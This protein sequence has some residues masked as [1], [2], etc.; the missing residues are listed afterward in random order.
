MSQT[1]DKAAGTQ[2]SC[3]FSS[4]L[5]VWLQRYIH[6]QKLQL[7]PAP[8][9][10]TVTSRHIVRGVGVRGRA[11]GGGGVTASEPVKGKAKGGRRAGVSGGEGTAPGRGGGMRPGE[12]GGVRRGRHLGDPAVHGLG[13]HHCISHQVCYALGASDGHNHLLLF[14]STQEGHTVTCAAEHCLLNHAFHRF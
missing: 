13:V 3:H 7:Q 2:A 5:S 6:Q 4:L 11:P 9:Q 1:V 14:P 10:K 8:G 12:G